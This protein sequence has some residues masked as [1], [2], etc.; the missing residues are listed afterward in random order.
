MQREGMSM[1]II[2]RH[3]PYVDPIE[4]LVIAAGVLLVVG[5]AAFVF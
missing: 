4:I 3:A 1:H 2:P 5:F